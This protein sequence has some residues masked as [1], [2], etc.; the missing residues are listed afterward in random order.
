MS[1]S[2]PVEPGESYTITYGDGK[3]VQA[4]ALGF[5]G[6]RK[7]VSLIDEIQSGDLKQAERMDVIEQILRLAIPDVSDEWLD[8]ITIDTATEIMSIAARNG[9]LSEEDRKKLESQP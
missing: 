3:T 6:Q 5:R 9:R 1:S 2:K 7:L 8:S 4:K